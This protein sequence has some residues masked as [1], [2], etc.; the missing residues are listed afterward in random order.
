MKKVLLFLALL[1]VGVGMYTEA[2]TTKTKPYVKWINEAPKDLTVEQ[3]VSTLKRAMKHEKITGAVTVANAEHYIAVWGQ[4]LYDEILSAKK[5]RFHFGVSK[6]S[7]K[8]YG[9]SLSGQ[10]TLSGIL[11]AGVPVLMYTTDEGIDIAVAKLG[12]TVCFNALPAASTEVALEDDP[13][14]Q[15]TLARKD[16]RKKLDGAVTGLKEG[17]TININNGQSVM[18]FYSAYSLGQGDMAKIEDHTV[19]LLKQSKEIGCCGSSNGFSTAST[20]TFATAST[21]TFQT[22]GYAQG[23]QELTVRV[24]PNATDIINTVFNGVNTLDNTVNTF[25]GIRFENQP[26]Q[27]Y[28]S[29]WGYSDWSNTGWNNGYSSQGG[30]SSNG[31]TPFYGST[32]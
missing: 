32:H 29:G 8:N 17:Q 22:T 14:N 11:N 10:A 20:V 15:P 27:A 9:I 26:R 30:Y 18:E 28:Y 3:A 2:Q 16:D 19:A 21:P 23:Q 7:E 12:Q 25:R 31:F 24:K 5:D 13:D 6:G 4:K 1:L